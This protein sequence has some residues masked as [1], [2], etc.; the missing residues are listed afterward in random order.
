MG[1]QRSDGPPQFDGAALKRCREESG[2]TQTELARLIGV[3]RGAVAQWES[4]TREPSF[5]NAVALAAA[6]AV[7]MQ[8]FVPKPSVETDD[9]G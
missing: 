8:V 3:T 6:L 2:L 9:N 4:G 1:A 7:D 5:G